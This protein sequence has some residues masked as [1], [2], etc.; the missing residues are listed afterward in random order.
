MTGRRFPP[1][2]VVG[3]KRVRLYHPNDSQRLAP[4]EEHMLHNTSRIDIEAP[5]LDR[6]PTFA[7]APCWVRHDMLGQLLIAFLYA[8]PTH[9]KSAS[10]PSSPP[11]NFHV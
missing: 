3:Q 10:T 8:E 7:S 1:A 9:L 6:Y 4:Y 5:D 11:F 2:K